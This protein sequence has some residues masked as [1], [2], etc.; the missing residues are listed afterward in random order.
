MSQQQA[1]KHDKAD[2]KPIFLLLYG[3]VMLFW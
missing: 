1:L 3:I 2:M